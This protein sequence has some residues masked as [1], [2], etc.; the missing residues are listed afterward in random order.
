MLNIYLSQLQN[1]NRERDILTVEKIN[2]LRDAM[3]ANMVGIIANLYQQYPGIISLENLSTDQL[4]S[5]FMQSN[6]NISR[7]LEWRLYNKFQNLGLVP[8][9]LKDSIL[10]RKDNNVKQFG[11][12]HFIPTENT[13]K[14]CPYCGETNTKN[15]TDWNKD[16]HEHRV[17]DCTNP[18]CGFNTKSKHKGMEAIDNPDTVASY[19]IAKALKD[20]LKK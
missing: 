1:K 9:R 20:K 3:A 17:F 18:Q 7:R 13:S 6:E 5:H 15:K 14:N 16:K 11:L 19:N 2:H 10:L 4:A 8:P 12:I